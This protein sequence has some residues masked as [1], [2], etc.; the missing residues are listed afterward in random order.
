TLGEHNILAFLLNN[1]GGLFN[2]AGQPDV[3]YARN[4]EAITFLTDMVKDGSLDPAGA[5]WQSSDLEKAFGQG[6]VAMIVDTPGVQGRFSADVAR[7]IG[8][9]N[10]LKSPHGTYGTIKWI[11]SLMIYNTTKYPDAA[12]TFVSWLARNQL[13]F[14]TQGH[15]TMLPV[16]H[17]SDSASYFKADPF[18]PRIFG[19]WLPIGAYTGARSKTLFPQLNAVEGQGFMQKM[20]QQI[21][22][23]QDPGSIIAGASAALADVMKNS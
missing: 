22:L 4:V 6:R 1:G 9:L 20:A 3:S 13:S 2:P 15:S 7:Q 17:S 12:M 8:L 19:E 14:W 16:T 11:A 5:G 23:G 21:S 10:P 18:A